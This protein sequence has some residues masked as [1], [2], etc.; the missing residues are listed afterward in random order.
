MRAI[1]ENRDFG[2]YNLIEVFSDM[3]KA[4]TKLNLLLLN[5]FRFQQHTYSEQLV[6]KCSVH[7]FSKSGRTLL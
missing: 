1:H 7:I 5:A 3:M 6:T 4:Q 2:N